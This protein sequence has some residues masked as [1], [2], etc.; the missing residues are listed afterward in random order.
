MDWRRK[1]MERDREQRR[2]VCSSRAVSL[3]QAHSNAR[4]LC[5]RPRVCQA[6]FE[7]TSRNLFLFNSL[8][9]SRRIDDRFSKSARAQLCRIN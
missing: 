8:F 2:A 7:D 4:N 6:H 5:L 1:G 3:L 9:C